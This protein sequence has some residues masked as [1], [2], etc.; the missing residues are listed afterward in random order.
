MPRAARVAPTHVRSSPC[1]QGRSFPC[2]DGNARSG[3]GHHRTQTGSPWRGPCHHRSRTTSRPTRPDP[4]LSP[5]ATTPYTHG[6]VLGRALHH[7]E[8][9]LRPIRS[10]AERTHH[11][12]TGEIVES[13]RGAVLPFRSSPFPRPAR[14]TGRAT[15]TA[16]GSPRVHA[17]GHA[18]ILTGIV[19]GP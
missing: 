5:N 2:A 15:F 16:S 18:L 12:L 7:T 8:R 1:D 19:G 4:V 17:S 3:T 6:R 13:D 10:H 14:R 11:G 9:N